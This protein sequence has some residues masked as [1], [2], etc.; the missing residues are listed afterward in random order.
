[1][2]AV[3]LV[4]LN[5]V[6]GAFQTVA[7]GHSRDWAIRPTWLCRNHRVSWQSKHSFWKPMNPNFTL[8]KIL[9]LKFKFVTVF[10]VTAFVTILT[11]RMSLENIWNLKVRSENL[12]LPRL[13][14]C[15][16]SKFFIWVLTV[17]KRLYCAP[18]SR[19]VLVN[20]PIYQLVY[21]FPPICG[22]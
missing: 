12:P 18:S 9:K 15:S 13:Q 19:R 10:S 4:S 5:L 21:I 7:G 17:F 1:M 6:H 22:E 14:V 3:R 2:V 16:Q 20:L 11:F 8:N